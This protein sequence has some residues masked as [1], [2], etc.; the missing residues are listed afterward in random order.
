MVTASLK[1]G[2]VIMAQVVFPG[3]V[4]GLRRL[5][6]L[7]AEATSFVGRAA[8]VAALTSLI[9]AARLVTVTGP[10]GVGKTRVGT[11]AAARVTG[12]FPDGVWLVELSEI[13]DPALLPGAVAAAAGLSEPGTVPQPMW[14]SGQL[15]D[16]KMLLILDTCEHL[17][18]ACAAFA[19]TV[20]RVAPDVTVLATSRQPLDAAGEHVFPV[21]PLPTE[22]AAV[23]LFAQRATAVV[24]GFAVTARNRADVV[25]LCG[26][27]D[28]IPL[29]IELA[30]L[31]L[32]ALPLTELADRL[33]SGF[34][35]VLTVSRRGTSPRHQTL[36]AALQWSYDLC[37]PAERVLWARL[38]VFAGAFDVSGAE[39]VC[40]DESLSRDAVMN[41]LV[42][43]VD[44][45]V[46]VREG[47]D[48]ARYRM[49]GTHRE[50]G[51]EQLAG[52]GSRE[53]LLDRLGSHYRDMTSR[54]EEADRPAGAQ[55]SP[56]AHVNGHGRPAA[57]TQAGADA[58]QASV[59]EGAPGAEPSPLTKREREIAALVAS[60]LSNRDIAA[61]LFISKRTVDAH[62]DHIFGKLEISSRVQ[63]AV[64]LHDQLRLATK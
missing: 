10:A 53:R 56:H 61:R 25:R 21:T 55:A 60:G 3:Q 6:L 26:T 58:R 4:T 57:G 23:E 59:A 17:I 35:R 63:L 43:L 20:L 41:A 37:A 30:A 9:G 16:K 34:F 12:W 64:L 38:S 27:L 45:S 8:E 48:A 28:G 33:E 19:E 14:I 36:W 13:R 2:E 7:P 40:A 39:D 5:G 62:V 31:R 49:L 22:S 11:N 15:R 44:K 18:D 32:R 52:G 47:G 1:F 42:G 54:L 50:F 46:V 51:A 29:A 24:P